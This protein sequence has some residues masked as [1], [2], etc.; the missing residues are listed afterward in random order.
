MSDHTPVFAK[1]SFM[2]PHCKAIAHQ[3]WATGYAKTLDKDETPHIWTS[4]DYENT[5][6]DHSFRQKYPDLY[7]DHLKQIKNCSIGEPLYIELNEGIYSDWKVENI[8]YSKCYSCDN[9]SIWRHN[10]LLYPVTQSQ[11][12]PNV[13]MPDEIRRDFLEAA[14]IIMLSPRGAC[15]LLRLAVQKLCMHLGGQGKN[16]N[17]DVALLVRNGLSKKVQKALDSVRVIGNEAVHPATLDLKDDVATASTLFSLVNYIVEAQITQNKLIDD[18]YEKLP[19][20]KVLQ[21]EARDKKPDST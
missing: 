3:F 8:N 14:E 16:I 12:L 2:C 17:D 10:V 5:K 11:Y 6:N 15:A 18:I 19:Q 1:P 9:I 7:D 13:D 21:I 4:E 20:S